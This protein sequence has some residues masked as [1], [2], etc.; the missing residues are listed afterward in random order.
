[1]RLYAFLLILGVFKAKNLKHL[2]HT[3]GHVI[4][5]FDPMGETLSDS[6]IPVRWG[7]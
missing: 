3:A 2:T 1:M 5:V 4:R 6:E 7:P